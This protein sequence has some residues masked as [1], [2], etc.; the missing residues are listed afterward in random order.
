MFSLSKSRFIFT[1]SVLLS[2]LQAKARDIIVADSRTHEP[3]SGASIFSKSGTLLGVSNHNGKLPYL[4]T[5]EFPITIRYIGFKERTITKEMS[6]TIFLTEKPKELAEV[7]VSSKSQKEL[8][9]LAYVREYSTLST[10]T[11]TVQMFREKTVDY[12]LPLSPKLNFRGWRNPRILCSRSYYRFT[13]AQGLDSVS[14]T[15]NNHFS[16]ADWVGI[17]PEVNLPKSVVANENVTD[18]IFGKYSRTETWVRN[19]DKLRLEVDVLADT[20]S[21]KWVPNLSAFFRTGLDYERFKLQANYENLTGNSVSPLELS[22]YSFIIESNGRGRDMF[23]FNRKDQ[24]IFVTTYAEVYILDREFIPISEARKWERGE[25][26]M[27]E[28]GIIEAPG[29]PPLQKDIAQL[30]DRVNNVDHDRVRL[31]LKPDERLVSHR[32]VRNFGQEM[33]MRLKNMFGISTL[34]GK[35]KRETKWRKF[36]EERKKNFHIRRFDVDS[37]GSL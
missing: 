36:R 29:A 5:S 24:P 28:I 22:E 27:D 10:Y 3:L 34:R 30:I 6:D 12:M 20:T 19:G 25:T 13:N 21:R 7:V 2:L 1:V 4:S 9:I 26:G 16:W 37:I 15:F 23:L 11:D 8:H 18:T 31:T 35:H 32:I 17:L 33:L 14:T